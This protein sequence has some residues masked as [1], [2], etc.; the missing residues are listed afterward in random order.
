MYAKHGVQ[1]RSAH[2]LG[3]RNRCVK[4][5]I[6]VVLQ[7]MSDNDKLLFHVV[8]QIVSEGRQA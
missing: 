1:A 3:D 4:V 7:V 2:R 6:A 8:R 5:L